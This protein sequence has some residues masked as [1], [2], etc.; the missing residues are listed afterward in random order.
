LQS[1]DLQARLRAQALEP[2]AINGAETGALLKATAERWQTV[3]KTA[4]IRPD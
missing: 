1:P 4:N 3:I 2:V